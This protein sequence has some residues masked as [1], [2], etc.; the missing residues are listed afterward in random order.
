MF[1]A[2]N[3]LDVE[4]W[5]IILLITLF[6]I[7]GCYNFLIS[8][9]LC[10]YWIIPR[11]EKRYQA[12]V[13]FD[14]PAMRYYPDPIARA[15]SC[16]NDFCMTVVY[17]YLGWHSTLLKKY[18]RYNGL[19]KINYDIRTA[20]KAELVVAFAGHASILLACGSG[21]I[22]IALYFLGVF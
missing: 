4:R 13:V 6:F 21:C 19:Y 5:S 12:K 10:R 9:L 17:A 3:Q 15:S 16:A 14:D 2:Y 1:L 20:T 8:P 11:I 18:A 7:C 22:L